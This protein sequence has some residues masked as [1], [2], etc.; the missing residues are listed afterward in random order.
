VLSLL[1]NHGHQ[2]PLHLELIRRV[3]R[4]DDRLFMRDEGIIGAIADTGLS[5]DT[6]WGARVLGP[7][8]HMLWI[9]EPTRIEGR[10]NHGHQELGSAEGVSGSGHGVGLEGGPGDLG[11]ASIIL[12]DPIADLVPD[13]KA[14][15][16]HTLSLLAEIHR[17][18]HVC[19]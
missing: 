7:P 10:R 19:V 1:A 17:L 2:F 9:I 6:G 13:L 14:T 11:H 18:Q 8:L 16:L 5:G 12:H 15:P 4:L 3:F